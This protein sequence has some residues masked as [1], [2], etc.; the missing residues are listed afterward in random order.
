M[1][2]R[3]NIF[4]LYEQNIGQVTPMIVDELRDAE[5]TWPVAWIE[6]AIELAVTSNVRKWRYIV[7][8]LKRWQQEGKQ[9][10]GLDRRHS[11]EKLRNQIPKEYQDLI[12]R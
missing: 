7:G 5:K 3:P 6:E 10:D 4:V 9:Q 1:V 11:P 2:E 12:K 8:I